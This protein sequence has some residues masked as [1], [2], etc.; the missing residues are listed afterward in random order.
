MS[1]KKESISM[2]ILLLRAVTLTG[3]NTLFT[4]CTNV[5]EPSEMESARLSNTKKM[6]LPIHRIYKYFIVLFKRP[7]FKTLIK[8]HRSAQMDHFHRTL[9]N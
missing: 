8:C 2:T 7:P 1:G 9:K 3:Y 4:V 6:P 5:F